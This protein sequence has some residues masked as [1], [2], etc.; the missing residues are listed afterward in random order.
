MKPHPST[1]DTTGT[2]TVVTKR[3]GP[4]NCGCQGKDPW[5]QAEYIRVLRDVQEESG[6]T[7]A[8]GSTR[9]YSR[10][11]VVQL[12]WGETRVVFVKYHPDFA[13]GVWYVDHESMLDAMN[14]PAKG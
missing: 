9:T 1:K 10:T 3:D 8:A 7:Y 6:S 14:A 2:R 4:C 12:P 13:S 11:A 5:H